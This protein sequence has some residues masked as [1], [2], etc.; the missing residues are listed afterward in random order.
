MGL[1]SLVFL[2]LLSS[3]AHAQDNAWERGWRSVPQL[4]KILRTVPEGKAVLERAT[5]KD[6]EF[7]SKIKLGSASFTEST[8]SRTYSLLDGKEQINLHHDVTLNTSLNLADAVVD[9]AHELV[10]FTEKGMLDPYKAGFERSEFIRNG[11]EGEGGE[12]SAL[13]V[14]CRVAWS[15]E[16]SYEGFPQHRLCERYRGGGNAF[17]REPARLDYYALGTSW[18]HRSGADLKRE[19][20]EVS[21]H[22][23]VFTS[24]YAGKPYPVA[25]SEEY[26]VTKKA[27]CTNNERKY[28]LISAQTATGRQPASGSLA[29]ERLRLRDYERRYCAMSGA[30]LDAPSD[31]SLS[32]TIQSSAVTSSGAGAPFAH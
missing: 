7:L 3:T 20:S 10:H 14:E 24:S 16:D 19:I 18:F 4:V 30:Q 1:L 28:H 11:I 15:L 29:A 5:K 31:D 22:S 27:A 12:L 13:T 23:T 21:S 17:L 26:A 8:F 32:S 6:P 25:L 9:L 2:A